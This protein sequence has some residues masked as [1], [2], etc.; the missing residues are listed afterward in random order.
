[1][2]LNQKLSKIFLLFYHQPIQ[3]TT[4][5]DIHFYQPGLYSKK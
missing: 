5:T 1:M 2:D 3:F 4:N